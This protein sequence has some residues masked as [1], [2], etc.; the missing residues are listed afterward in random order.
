MSQTLL[1]AVVVEPEAKAKASI[2]WLHGLG[3]DGYDFEGIVPQLKTHA[4]LPIRF[5]FPHA[6]LRPITL[7]GGYVMRGW[8]D[9]QGLDG[10][11]PEDLPGIQAS[12]NAIAAWIEHEHSQGIAYDKIILAGFSQGGA[13]ALYCGLRYP[14]RLGG[15]MALSTYLPLAKTLAQEAAPVQSDIPIF[16]AHGTEDNIVMLPWAEQSQAYLKHLGYQ[17]AWH[18]YPMPHSVCPAEVR[19]IA[20][21][22]NDIID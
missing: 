22:L 10:N 2:I 20:V 7:N 15:I 12:S 5:I 3:A 9:I 1:P 13:I 4:N 14:Q 16:F 19:D 21:W 6:P 18:T 8:Y 17:L 11:A